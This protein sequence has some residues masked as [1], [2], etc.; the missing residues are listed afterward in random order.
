[1]CLPAQSSVGYRR[2]HSEGVL[3]M[4]GSPRSTLSCPA[5]L[6]PLQCSIRLRGITPAV[7]TAHYVWDPVIITVHVTKIQLV[8]PELQPKAM[9]AEHRGVPRL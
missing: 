8:E 7:V 5:T 4:D 1:M 6:S 9:C 3:N 2:L